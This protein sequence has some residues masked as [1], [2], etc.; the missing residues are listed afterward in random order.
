M[1]TSTHHGTPP[2]SRTPHVDDTTPM[3]GAAEGYPVDAGQAH[4]HV[5]V[6]I[7]D[8]ALGGPAANPAHQQPA[9]PLPLTLTYTDALQAVERN[10]PLMLVGL[11]AGALL[12]LLALFVLHPTSDPNRPEWIYVTTELNAIVASVLLFIFAMMLV[13]G[14]VIWF[15]TRNQNVRV[16]TDARYDYTPRT[17]R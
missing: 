6:Q 17:Q 8:S 15:A 9:A 3:E 5:N 2:N 1:S 13:A 7:G 11:L 16:L 12:G 10:I 4:C 14:P